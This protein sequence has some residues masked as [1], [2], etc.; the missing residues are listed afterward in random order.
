MAATKKF[1]WL[2]YSSNHC[3]RESGKLAIAHQ[4]LIAIALA[5][6]VFE[7]A[8]TEP[9]RDAGNNFFNAV[10][11]GHVLVPRPQIFQQ[12]HFIILSKDFKIFFY[13]NFTVKKIN[14]VSFHAMIFPAAAARA[15]LVRSVPAFARAAGRLCDVHD[16]KLS[17][18]NNSVG[19]T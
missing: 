9:R 11:N 14:L 8:T 5:V 6:N 19:L 4:D 3:R 1:V 2:F 16:C 15:F 10:G 12:N 13:H 7:P 18:N 17:L